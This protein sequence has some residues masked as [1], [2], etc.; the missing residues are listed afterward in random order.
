MQEIREE[1]IDSPAEFVH[2]G[3]G[4]AVSIELGLGRP[5][6]RSQQQ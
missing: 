1:K 3:L 4:W 5:N 2:D 6:C